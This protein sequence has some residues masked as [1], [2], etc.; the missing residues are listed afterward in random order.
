MSALGQSSAHVHV[1]S[2]LPTK[3]DI[4]ATAPA[5]EILYKNRKQ[6]L[7]CSR[8]KLSRST[9]L[10]APRAHLNSAH[11]QA[12]KDRGAPENDCGS[13]LHCRRGRDRAPP[14]GRASSGTCSD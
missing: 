14:C 8:T 2:A 6:F 3:A 11:D 5:A 1:M 12:R 7:T 13:R 10:N 4:E 9:E